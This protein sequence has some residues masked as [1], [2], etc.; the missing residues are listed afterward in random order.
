MRAFRRSDLLFFFLCVCVCVFPAWST[1]FKSAWDFG[2]FFRAQD[3]YL[4]CGRNCHAK[5]LTSLAPS[6]GMIFVAIIIPENQPHPATDRNCL[7]L[8][9]KKGG[10]IWPAQNERL[11][12]RALFPCVPWQLGATWILSFLHPKSHWNRKNFLKIN[13][14]Q[15]PYVLPVYSV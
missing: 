2:R 8:S 7:F 4:P 9:R 14:G 1:F 13:D 5:S 6:E 11:H 15:M 12:E 3:V 10:M